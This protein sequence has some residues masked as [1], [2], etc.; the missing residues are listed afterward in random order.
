VDYLNLPSHYN[1]TKLFVT[2]P[3]GYNGYSEQFNYT[4]GEAMACGTPVV[5][6]DNGSLLGVYKNA[7]IVFAEEEEEQ[8]LNDAIEYVFEK[9]R[10]QRVDAG[11]KWVHE[12]LSNTAIALKLGDILKGV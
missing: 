11:I 9:P 12:Y 2:Y 1:R 7:P 6:S 4:I 10:E 8:S 3:Y 5:T